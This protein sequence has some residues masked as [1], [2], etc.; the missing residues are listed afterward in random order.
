MI[1]DEMMVPVKS[2]NLKAIG[3]NGGELRVDFKSSGTYLYKAVPVEIMD[4]FLKAPSA[5]CFF[6]NHIRDKYEFEKVN[7][8]KSII[9]EEV[10]EN[11]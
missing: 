3:Y 6:F 7:P 4:K 9:K 5:G 1:T 10:K 11:G 2:S 8:E